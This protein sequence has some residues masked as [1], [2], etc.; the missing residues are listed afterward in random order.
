MRVA[1][2]WD[3]NN[4]QSQLLSW[5]DGLAAALEVLKKDITLDCYTQV[6]GISDDGMT[7]RNPHVDFKAFPTWELMAKAIQGQNYDAYLFFADLTR[8]ALNEMAGEKPTALC[9]TGGWADSSCADRISLFFV[10]SKPYLDKFRRDGRNVVQAFGTNTRLFRP[11]N[12]ERKV[13]DAVFPA[14]FAEW[15]RHALFAEALGEKGA[16]F[17]FFQD[18]EPWCYDDCLKSGVF[19][20]PHV[21][22]YLIPFFYDA[23][24]T[25]VITS[26]AAGGSQR[27]VLEAMACNIPV[28]IMKDSDKTSEYIEEAGPNAGK[29]VEPTVEAI[30]EA[31]LEFKVSSAEP[32]GRAYIKSKWSEV[33]YANEILEG[34]KSIV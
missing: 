18:H 33:H 21:P 4:D 25:C 14:T 20:L 22:A 24:H 5:Q 1:L 8:P 34:L 3:W 30:R 10:E 17:G 19:T 26:N 9:F 23:A 6:D 27:T 12:R 2:I 32:T 29:I 11:L 16:A 28:I 15:K 31:V 7:F 13:W